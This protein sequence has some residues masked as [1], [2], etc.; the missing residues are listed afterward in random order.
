[1]FVSLLHIIKN[2]HKINIS[3]LYIVSS[4]IFFIHTEEKVKKKKK[5]YCLV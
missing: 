3:N 2:K 4:L 1:V 5:C